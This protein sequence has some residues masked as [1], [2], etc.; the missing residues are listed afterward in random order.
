MVAVRAGAVRIADGTGTAWI[1][2]ARALE[3]GTWVRAVGAWRAHDATLE[4]PE[5]EASHG[6]EPR[7]GSE[8]T[9]AHVPTQGGQSRFALLEE[10]ARVIRAVRGFFEAAGFLEVETPLVVPS[11]GL[12]LHL[13]AFEVRGAEAARW[14]VTSPEY[15]MKRLL[16]AGH[17]RI[18]Q[19]CKC[20]RRGELGALHEPEFTMLEWYRAFAG[21]NDVM[22]D[23]ELLVEHVA[24]AVSGSTL[25]PALG[26]QVDVRAPWERLTVRD[27]L[28][29]YA[30]LALDEVVRDEE[31]FFRA[32]VEKVEPELGRERP[33]WLV[34]W[35]A[36]MA[37]L[38]RLDPSDPSVAD[39]FEAY[40]AGLELC[41]GFGE[42]V[43]AREQRA[44]LE[45]DQ[46]ARS[47]TGKP[48]YPIDERFLA[49]LE[50]GI[51]PSG[52]NALGVDR[53][54][55]LVLGAVHI[56]DIVAIPARRL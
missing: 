18:F 5:L 35:P 16:A 9:W 10:R 20:F 12:D 56:E 30:G 23:T 37:S 41:N 46:R 27:A 38:A 8:H 24:R 49:A 55:M 7:E 43:D 31:R 26:R 1:A 47:A 14:L 53:L 25:V 15:Q 39:R 19:L 34:G 22:A 13:D 40:V 6:A 4:A 28:R 33:I 17:A 50:E 54:V 2:T 21:S 48:I 32:L 45:R 44:R 29:K 36:S 3:P 11:P 51:P 42:L 52:G